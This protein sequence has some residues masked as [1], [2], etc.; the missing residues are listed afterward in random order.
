MSAAELATRPALAVGR[1]EPGRITAI[2][3]A[4]LARAAPSTGAS[5]LP[6]STGYARAGLVDAD[7]VE[8]TLTACLAL[9]AQTA[10]ESGQAERAFRLQ[11]AVSALRGQVQASRWPPAGGQP[12]PAARPASARPDRGRRPPAA[13]T[14]LTERQREVAALITR[15]LTNR[16]IADALVIAERT[17]DT[18][19][20]NIL[21]K[22]GLVSRTQIAA[23]AVEQGVA[24]SQP[25]IWR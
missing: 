7:L 25:E 10:A 20:E 24:S 17:A 8:Q 15:G 12:G 6:A 16:E 2:R 4:T 18:H 9:L 21:N 22:L 5:A 1:I 23:W 14:P 13:A 19:V 3:E 11:G